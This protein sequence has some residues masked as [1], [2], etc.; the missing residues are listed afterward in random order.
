MAKPH[1]KGSSSLQSAFDPK[2]WEKFQAL[3]R[4]ASSKNDLQPQEENF[5]EETLLRK[6]ALKTTSLL[7]RSPLKRKTP[8]RAKGRLDKSSS[9]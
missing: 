7:R 5:E 2:S 4:S 8:F 6:K 1:S 3:T 9:D